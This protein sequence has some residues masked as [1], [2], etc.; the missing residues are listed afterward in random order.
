MN[1]NIAYELTDDML[2]AL[3]YLDT[4][5]EYTVLEPIEVEVIDL[6]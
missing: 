4:V 5:D 3:C 6:E 2:Y 1:I